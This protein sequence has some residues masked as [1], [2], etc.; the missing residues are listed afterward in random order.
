MEQPRASPPICWP[1]WWNIPL[2]CF[3]ETVTLL[4]GLAGGPVCGGTTEFFLCVRCDFWGF[5]G[6]RCWLLHFTCT[7]ETYPNQDM[8]L[9]G[10]TPSVCVCVC[11]CV[12]VSVVLAVPVVLQKGAEPTCF[13]TPSSTD[14][15]SL[16]RFVSDKCSALFVTHVR[17]A[18]IVCVFVCVSVSLCVWAGDPVDPPPSADEP[19]WFTA[20]AD[21][22]AYI[23]MNA[24]R[25]LRGGG[26]PWVA[27]ASSASAKNGLRGGAVARWASFWA[28]F[29]TEL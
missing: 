13:S 21:D 17:L 28:T 15:F 29:D 10:W 5:W 26:G 3:A 11:V 12:C 19:Q 8:G 24:K 7:C 2:W 27:V 4:R 14:L 18:S 25:T 1:S 16:T 23:S 9:A 6:S 20:T 22:Q